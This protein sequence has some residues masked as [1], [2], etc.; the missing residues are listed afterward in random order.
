MEDDYRYSVAYDENVVRVSTSGSFDY[1]KALEMWKEIMAT[2]EQHQCFDILA[3][4]LVAK[5]LPAPDL[6]NSG[7]FFDA[8]GLTPRHRLAVVNNNEDVRE[9]Y[10]VAA[11]AL[12][13]RRAAAPFSAA[14]F[15]NER[16]AR[17]WL[18]RQD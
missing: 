5:P 12:K 7:E 14:A 11:A 17:R 16:D 4:S 6:F 2:C 8:V 3:I 13:T 10:K 18:S 15:S 9:S 1:L